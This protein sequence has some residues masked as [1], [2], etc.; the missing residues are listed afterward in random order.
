MGALTNML[1][2]ASTSI[3]LM[4]RPLLHANTQISINSFERIIIGYICRF[5]NRLLKYYCCFPFFF[6]VC[7]SL[8]AVSYPKV[9]KEP[10]SNNVQAFVMSA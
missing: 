6:P 9:Q 7:F 8:P 4:E 2:E 3:A 1:S 5:Q 10:N